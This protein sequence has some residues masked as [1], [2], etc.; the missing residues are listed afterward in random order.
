MNKAKVKKNIANLKKIKEIIEISKFDTLQKLQKASKI[1]DTY[2][3]MAISAKGLIDFANSTYKIKNKD[4]KA[5]TNATL[6]VYVT[7]DT[8][9]MSVSNAKFERIIKNEI[10]IE[11][12]L[13]IALGDKAT[14][15]ASENN[16]NI[17]FADKTSHGHEDTIATSIGTSIIMGLIS[18]VKFVINSPKVIDKSITIY[19]LSELNIKVK[20]QE[21]NVDKNY[22]FFPSIAHSLKSLTQI[23][24]YR[25]VYAL[26]KESQYFHL[27]EKL[28][29]H[30]GSIKSVDSKIEEKIRDM[31][32]L[33]RKVETEE[34]ILVSQIAKRGGEDE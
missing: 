4:F 14:K 24:I 2:L 12:D 28:I 13:I 30:E 16:L 20:D 19:P 27:K 18:T 15:F 32:K 23:Y 3:E 17:S 8:E 9:L 26:I 22:K 34:L 29:R 11:N 1:S 6:W 33:N 25:M 10:D 5:K 21:I 7:P 31:N